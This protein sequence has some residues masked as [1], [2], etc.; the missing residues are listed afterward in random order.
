MAFISKK[1]NQSKTE[2]Q[3]RG[4]FLKL[5]RENPHSLSEPLSFKVISSDI[6]IL[7]TVLDTGIISF[8]PNCI[9]T[10][11]IVLSS[12]IHGNETAPIEICNNLIK[13]LIL[14]KIKLK[15]RV[16]FIF[17]NPPAINAS[18][19][20]IEEN[21]N[22]LFSG[23]HSKPLSDGSI[24]NNRERTRAKA[25][26]NSVRGF[27]YGGEQISKQRERYHYDLHTSIRASKNDKFAVSPFQ[28]NKPRKKEP[29]LFLKQCGVTTVLLANAPTKAFTFFTVNEFATDAF[30]IELGKVKG[31]GENNIDDFVEIKETLIACI[32]AKPIELGEYLPENFEV[33]E[34]YQNIYRESE[35]FKLK[36]SDD[37]ENFTSFPIGTVLATDGNKII[38]VT[39]EGEAI[40]F[41]NADVSIGQRALLTVIP[42]RIK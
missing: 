29:L 8:E 36:F 1:I 2:L 12:G 31:F 6:T 35:V 42:T 23:E 18:K 7:V 15:E 4:D 40:I 41:P 24:L 32:S 3:T 25:L 14:G 34:V 26:E 16:L 10:K 11:D 9:S 22:L 37:I 30:T 17:G 28:H 13:D 5:T 20:F 39:K 21:L 38:K 19:R 27:Y 33:F